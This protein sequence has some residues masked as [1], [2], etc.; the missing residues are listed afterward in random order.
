MSF[1]REAGAGG[2]E[3][4][5]GTKQLTSSKGHER[6]GIRHH[7]LETAFPSKGIFFLLSF[8]SSKNA[9]AH[10][11]LCVQNKKEL[12]VKVKNKPWARIRIM[13]LFLVHLPTWYTANI[14]NQQT[15]KQTIVTKSTQK[16]KK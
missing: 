15:D 7:E 11:C 6:M 4:S 14:N 16:I 3:R 13:S 10:D 12:S 5:R 9:P 8:F 1:W 2:G